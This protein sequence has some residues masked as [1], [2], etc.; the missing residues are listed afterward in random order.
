MEKIES[1]TP[2]SSEGELHLFRLNDPDLAYAALPQKGHPCQEH[3]GCRKRLP[4]C[5]CRNTKRDTAFLNALKEI[6][7]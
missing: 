6:V 2:L 7:S 1:I 5:H 4:P 3:K